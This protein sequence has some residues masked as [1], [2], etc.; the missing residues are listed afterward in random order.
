MNTKLIDVRSE[1]VVYP[2]IL[3]SSSY[4]QAWCRRRRRL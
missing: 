1:Y 2:Y 4:R 3:G